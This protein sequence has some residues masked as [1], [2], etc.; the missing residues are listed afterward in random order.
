MEM[1]RKD[2]KMKTNEETR[3]GTAKNQ[4]REQNT[5]I[6]APNG[7]SV[8]ETAKAMLREMDKNTPSNELLLRGWS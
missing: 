5:I 3:S 4:N 7:I 2:E 1:E 8:S 6:S